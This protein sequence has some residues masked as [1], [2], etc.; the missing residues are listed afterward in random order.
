[1][2]RSAEG[3]VLQAM[4]PRQQL[5]AVTS[6]FASQL[7]RGHTLREPAQDQDPL[8]RRTLRPVQDRRGEGVEDPQAVRTAI[9]QDRRAIVPMDLQAVSS[10]TAGTGQALGMQEV[11][12]EIVASL[13][14]HE[15]AQ[16]KVHGRL[17]IETPR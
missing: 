16:G 15:I 6:Q 11:D 3:Q 12:Q 9:D 8:P 4:A 10:V 2:I 5:R 7:S 17:Q 1:L 14:V 13:F